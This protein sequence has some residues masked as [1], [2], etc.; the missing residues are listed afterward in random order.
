MTWLR[1][2]I[3]SI[4]APSAYAFVPPMPADM[5]LLVTNAFKTSMRIHTAWVLRLRRD[6]DESRDGAPLL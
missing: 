3:T 5:V 4:V 2:R 6:T 1:S